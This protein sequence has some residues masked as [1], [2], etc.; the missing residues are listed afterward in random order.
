[1]V[2][3]HSW[4]NLSHRG[5]Q[6]QDILSVWSTTAVATDN[7]SSNGVHRCRTEIH[8]ALLCTD[9]HKDSHRWHVSAIAG[10]EC[11]S[12]FGVALFS[13]VEV[14]SGGTHLRSVDLERHT[15]CGL[16]ILL[17]KCCHSTW[18]QGEERKRC[19]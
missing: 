9:V 3:P 13:C 10:I 8:R 5:G 11:G 2:V 15:P 17:D 6:P 7:L 12:V 14:G 4:S 19:T 18:L 1:M 16:L